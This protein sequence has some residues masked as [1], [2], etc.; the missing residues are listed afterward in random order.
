MTATDRA[1][2]CYLLEPV[3]EHDSSPHWASADLG[4]LEC[5]VLAE[6][7][8]RAREY[9]TSATIQATKVTE[10]QPMPIQPWMDHGLST[11]TIDETHRPPPGVVLFAGGAT[12]TVR[13]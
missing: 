13:E 7:E 6:D 4:P 10:G 2:R 11:C 5:W 1:L 12:R 3:D 8:A 9:V